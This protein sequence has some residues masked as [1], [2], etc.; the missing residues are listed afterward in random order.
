MS[1]YLKG[2]KLYWCMN[3]PSFILAY[4]SNLLWRRMES[5]CPFAEVFGTTMIP[6]YRLLFKQ[7][8][9]GAYATIEQDANGCV[10]A[11][12]YQVT[13]EDEAALDRFEGYPRY[14]YKREFFLP[15]WNPEGKKLRKRRNCV[16][17]IMHE[18][19]MLGEPTEEYYGI[20]EQGYTDWDFDL[21]ILEKALSDSIGSKAAARWL[22]ERKGVK[23]E[24]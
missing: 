19:R 9:T 4:G 10:P 13:P 15:V 12:V 23:T 22:N 8:R 11:V 14:Y 16:A 24:A 1:D 5:R 3:E 6:G 7:S 18:D 17:Y 2:M 21:R 20:V